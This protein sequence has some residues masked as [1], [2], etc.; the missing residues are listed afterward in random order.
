MMKKSKEKIIGVCGTVILHVLLGLLLYFLVLDP[1]PP[2]SSEKGVEVMLGVDMEDGMFEQ[3]NAMPEPGAVVKP[4]PVKPV[5]PETATPV[6]PVPEEPV[7]TQDMEE[8]IALPKEQPKK[9]KPKKEEKPKKDKKKE[10]EKPKETEKPKEPVKTPEQIEREKQIADSLARVQR[11]QDTYNEAANKMMT[12]SKGS[13]MDKAAESKKEEA[14]TGS[15]DGNSI[16]GLKSGV[17]VGFDLN[18]RQPGRDGIVKPEEKFK[19]EGRVVVDITVDPSGRV[20][21]AS[22]NLQ[23]TDTADP[24]LRNAAYKAAMATI[25]N[26]IDGVD[27]QHGTITY[28]FNLIK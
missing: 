15:P 9:E 10:P 23:K 21:V 5:E 17:G 25:F 8:S 6:T 12:F 22:I 3:P 26:R 16:D 20:I 11:E 27:N 7:I 24:E 18:G 13:K 2:P 14:S 28:N 1:T 4:E 19:K